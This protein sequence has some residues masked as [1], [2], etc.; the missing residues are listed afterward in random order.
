MIRELAIA[1]LT[2][3]DGISEEAYTLMYEMLKGDN[4]I[5]DCV[6]AT[7]GRFY[8]PEGWEGTPVEAALDDLERNIRAIIPGADIQT[9]NDDQLVIY[10]GL[11]LAAD[12]R[13]VSL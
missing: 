9:D 3:E 2:Q 4:D 13:V 5:T 10:T 1:L 11:M 6:E 7:D 8:L 12:G